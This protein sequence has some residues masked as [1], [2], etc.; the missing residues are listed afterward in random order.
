MDSS[1]RAK[2]LKDLDAELHALQEE[3]S[4][5][6]SQL[7]AVD[8]R[9]EHN[10]KKRSA[11]VSISILDDDILKLII[12]Q[13]CLPVLPPDSWT[14]QPDLS[15][16]AVS[17]ISRRWREI[18]FSLPYIWRT[19]CISTDVPLLEHFVQHS[20]QLPLHV[21]FSDGDSRTQPVDTT[22]AADIHERLSSSLSFLL[23]YRPRWDS[24]IFLCKDSELLRIFLKHTRNVELPMLSNLELY[25][26]DYGEDFDGDQL[27]LPVCQQLS[28]LLLSAVN[29][30]FHS[31]TL[32]N[33]QSMFLSY[34]TLSGEVLHALSAAAP[35]LAELHLNECGEKLVRMP[36]TEFPCLK[37]LDIRLTDWEDLFA[38]VRAP[39]LETL[40]LE[41]TPFW[42]DTPNI[43]KQ[44][45][46]AVFPSLRRLRLCGVI[47]QRHGHNGYFFRR[48]PNLTTLE[49]ID[50]SGP[51]G[52]IDS[53][54]PTGSRA[55]G[56]PFLETLTFT[57]DR[58]AD[59][60]DLD[61]LLKFVERRVR[62]PSPLREVKLSGRTRA[63]F[64]SEFVE[65]MSRLITLTD[66]VDGAES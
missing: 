35:N 37:Y 56:L 26:Q 42:P 61:L 18:A 20:Q 19:I 33:V 39:A 13:A 29:I 44:Y 30:Q 5:L 22:G 16:T 3:E 46:N 15:P 1:Q 4:V 24:C 11:L 66:F 63:L 6:L 57:M 54:S 31:N 17:H 55:E 14:W 64:G 34:N 10:R 40:L 49:L 50:C 43:A 28:S 60:E 27:E 38:A 52:I 51:F 2:V 62:R 59:E 58:S 25:N 65:S 7:A 32:R 9:I 45:P 12:E 21:V 41:A 47:A 48:V 36:L 23:R 8:Q 53:I